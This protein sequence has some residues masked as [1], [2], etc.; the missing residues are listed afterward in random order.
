MGIVS[1]S[2]KL[3][4]S[5]VFHSRSTPVKNSFSYNVYYIVTPLSQ[6]QNLSL[7]GVFGIDHWSL[8]S[9]YQ[10]DYGMRDGSC[11]QS[12]VSKQLAS[13][14]LKEADGEVYLVT[15][16]RVLGYAFN[17][18]S[19]WFCHDKAGGLRAVLCEVNN[20][21]RE[22]HIYLCAHKDHRPI[23]ANERIEAKKEFH[24][25]PFLER[26]GR[27][28]FRFK[29]DGSSCGVWIDHFDDENEKILSTS[30]VGTLREYTRRSLI[31]AF[32]RFPFETLKVISLIHW[33][34]L[35]LYFK[36]VQYVPKPKQRMPN[37]TSSKNLTEI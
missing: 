8:F 5:K 21:F 36:R 31:L 12:W 6:L 16:P 17:P 37:A 15:M 19:F 26:V 23:L 7:K 24:V 2:P 1:N 32:I 25:S 27:Y 35:K 34:A 29:S 10:K 3:L 22:H 33:Q 14:D 4:T 30:V 20:T 13:F 11:L 18:V 9:F 28:E